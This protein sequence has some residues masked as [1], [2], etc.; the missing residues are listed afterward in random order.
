MMFLLCTVALA[1]KKPEAPT[2]PCSLQLNQAPPLRGLR[3]GMSQA[4]VLAQLPGVTVEKPDK[5]GLARLRISVFDASGVIKTPNKEK[6]VEQDPLAT[7]DAGSAFVVDARKFPALQ[8]VRKI[9]MRF[10]D[11]RL[12][13]LNL[14]YNDQVS[15]ESLDQFVDTIST[16]L[17][18][19][20]QW[21][22][23]QDSD[24]QAKEL[25]CTGFTITAN[26]TGDPS[27]T[28]VG[29]E[30]ILQDAA[31]WEAM[32]KRQNE[33]VEKAKRDEDAKR[34]SFKP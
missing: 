28:H 32:S 13:Y 1:Q 14:A 11:G 34:K 20:N 6:A 26:L 7:P 30:L 29:P 18:L 23:P 16:A 2:A 25:R 15:W 5:F 3:I 27:D 8:G 19:P 31:A 22:T 24:S 12:A 33:L 17:K 4:A 9:D 21:Q 10:I